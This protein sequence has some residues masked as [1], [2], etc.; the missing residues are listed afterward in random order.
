MTLNLLES[1]S[2]CYEITF[3]ECT[4]S[5]TADAGL[6]IN[7][8]YY[9]RISDKFGNRYFNPAT[10]DADG[11][12]TIRVSDLPPGLF[13]AAAGPFILEVFVQEFDCEPQQLTLCNSPYACIIIHFVHQNTDISHPTQLIPCQCFSQVPQPTYTSPLIS[14]QG[15]SG[16][17]YHYQISSTADFTNVLLAEAITGNFINVNGLIPDGGQFY[18]RIRNAVDDSSWSEVISFN[19][20]GIVLD[21][22]E[23]GCLGNI[24]EFYFTLAGVASPVVLIG[25]IDE[26]AGYVNVISDT[27]NNGSSGFGGLHSLLSGIPYNFRIILDGG[28]VISNIINQQFTC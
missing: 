12:F 10:T 25:Q 3:P 1:C 19:V 23:Y 8:P 13:T 4:E 5:I 16:D 24:I 11:K 28:V 14:W 22:V 27:F 6:E 17:P 7:T 9:Y 26:G 20:A 21:S 18:F 2:A 15:T